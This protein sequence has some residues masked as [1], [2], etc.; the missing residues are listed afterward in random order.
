[1]YASAS[2]PRDVPPDR[3][4][5]HLP[6][7][8]RPGGEPGPN[9]PPFEDPREK[10]RQGPPE[11]PR[12]SSAARRLAYAALVA[13]PLTVM[14]STAA[15]AE[16]CQAQLERF[17]RQYDLSTTAPQAKL[18]AGDPIT[19]PTAPMTTESRGLSTTGKLKDS[20]GVIKPPDTGAARVMPPPETGDRMAT[21]PDVK[22]HSG[23]GQAA[24]SSAPQ[25][26]AQLGAADR[27]KLEA[28]LMAG[29]EAAEK[30]QDR[31]CMERLDEARGIIERKSR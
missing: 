7:P 22:P 17:A 29:R 18:R 2:G 30:G 10:P 13:A 20:G 12:E 11:R 28:L 16:S 25:G 21:A 14:L 5:P 31:T 1:M 3:S 19:P 24:G 26:D 6:D 9:L 27:S 23:S 15:A 4:P 8:H